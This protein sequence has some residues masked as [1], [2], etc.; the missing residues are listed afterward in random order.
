VTDREVA[1]LKA[2]DAASYDDQEDGGDG[3][4]TI[5]RVADEIDRPYAWAAECLV[6]LVNRGLAERRRRRTSGGRLFYAV[7][8][9]GGTLLLAEDF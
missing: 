4:V 7:S 5:D 8:A 6:V 9:S 1:A 2:L 3:W